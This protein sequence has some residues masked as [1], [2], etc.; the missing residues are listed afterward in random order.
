MERCC[1]SLLV[2][3]KKLENLCAYEQKRSLRLYGVRQGPTRIERMLHAAT[4]AAWHAHA[5]MQ[6]AREIWLHAQLCHPAVIAMY[7]AWK[8]KEHI[9]LALEWADEVGLG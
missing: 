6:V 9:Y 8:D 4:H 7:A 1:I 2:C 5:C 3:K